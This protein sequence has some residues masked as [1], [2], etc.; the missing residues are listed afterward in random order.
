MIPVSEAVRIV[1][2]VARPLPPESIPLEDALGRATSST[3]RTAS[4]T[5]IIARV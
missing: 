1:L 4:E 2:D 5:G 3:M